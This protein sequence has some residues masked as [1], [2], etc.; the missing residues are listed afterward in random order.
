MHRCVRPLIAQIRVLREPTRDDAWT[1][2][3]YLQARR[4][5]EMCAA[6]AAGARSAT[7]ALSLEEA[8]T[9]TTAAAA[10]A[11]AGAAVAGGAEALPA[12]VSAAVAT[13]PL[14]GGAEPSPGSA[15]A[16][17]VDP[18]IAGLKAHATP[19]ML[20]RCGAGDGERK[21]RST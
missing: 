11:A 21:S 19:T 4:A 5:G 20:R 2:D 9:P 15:A 7:L 6:A 10:E 3:A 18:V 16:E 8:S 12:A 14:V 1:G 13:A 17:A